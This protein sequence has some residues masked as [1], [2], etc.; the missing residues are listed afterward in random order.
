MSCVQHIISNFRARQKLFQ[1]FSRYQC[2]KH[3]VHNTHSL[4]MKDSAIW[5][6]FFKRILCTQLH[7]PLWPE[8]HFLHTII[9]VS[10]FFRPTKVALHPTSISNGT[11]VRHARAFLLT[12]AHNVLP[13]HTSVNHAAQCLCS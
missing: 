5:T 6:P 1:T 8:E 9:D 2:M 3:A 13:S 10:M 11:R 7:E 12:F 4:N